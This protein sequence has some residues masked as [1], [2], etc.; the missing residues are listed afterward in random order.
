MAIKKKITSNIIASLVAALACIV[1]IGW[2]FQ[3]HAVVQLLPNLV[4]MQFNTALCFL[5]SAGCLLLY[6]SNYKVLAN[7]L[8][9]ILLVITALTLA[10][11]AFNISFGIDTLFNQPFVT[12]K[13]SH[14]GRMAPNTA[15][16]F[17]L[18]AI[19]I[20]LCS[21][22]IKGTYSFIIIFPCTFGILG[23]LSFLGYVFSIEQG[24][25]WGTLTH[26]ALH[27]SVGFILLAA[28]SLI[29]YSI[30]LS[31]T[32]KRRYF[33]YDSC[34]VAAIMFIFFFGWL[35][36]QSKLVKKINHKTESNLTSLSNKLEIKINSE[37]EAIVRIFSRYNTGAYSTVAALKHDA[38]LYFEHMR[39]LLALDFRSKNSNSHLM[40]TPYINKSFVFDKY[41]LCQRSQYKM[42]KNTGKFLKTRLTGKNIL[43][44][45]NKKSF[46]VI[47]LQKMIEVF[48]KSEPQNYTVLVRDSNKNILFDDNSTNSSESFWLSSTFI[49]INGERFEVSMVPNREVVGQV[50]GT[51]PYF[52]FITAFLC[53]II[54]LYITKS[55]RGIKRREEKIKD[56]TATNYAIMHSLTDGV[57]GVNNKLII[58]YMNQSAEKLL[59]YNYANKKG[60]HLDNV[61]TIHQQQDGFIKSARKAI[62]NLTSFKQDK[63]VIT[64]TMGKEIPTT[65][66]TS[67]IFDGK[68]IK[69]AIIVF[70]DISKRLD[71]EKKLVRL[72]NYDPLTGLPNRRKFLSKLEECVSKHQSD[73][74]PFCLLFLDI[75]DFKLIND[76]YGHHTGDKALKFLT[77]VVTK[78]ITDNMF[79]ARLS[80]DEFCL[81]L[82]GVDSI[83]DA[84]KLIK[85]I[86]ERLKK[87][88]VI[89]DHRIIISVSIGCV[90]HKE[91]M[92][93]KALL[94]QA[95]KEMYE[96]KKML[97]LNKK[98]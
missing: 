84:N 53:C 39:F 57:I 49:T 27:T 2:L 70:S 6:N 67:P 46:A 60:V 47:N 86:Q 11:Y 97:K 93:A 38:G 9:V 37:L 35:L 10:Q 48:M 64:T 50:L 54:A 62:K 18:F 41:N 44:V 65:F 52:L 29:S 58:Q 40:Y 16:A 28:A 20:L 34:I 7:F 32:K 78:E 45:F 3:I 24:Y 4:P 13:T 55:R 88:A 95:D 92:S 8:A 56:L 96:Q 79:F 15:I 43:C 5:I 23:M 21:S 72:A 74:H 14:A 63:I 77:N 33:I 68:N 30:A 42:L 80:G 51:R 17:I 81:I 87:S 90:I 36:T 66:Q 12:T 25:A 19:F 26:M 94:I 91:S 76:T 82:E 69:G 89:D 59:D 85:N 31:I 98:S 22:K 61:V 1:L 75:N 71:Y 83:D 73:Q